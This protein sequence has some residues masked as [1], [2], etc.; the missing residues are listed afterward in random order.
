MGMTRNLKSIAIGILV[1]IVYSCTYRHFD[2][3]LF[4]YSKDTVVNINVSNVHVWN[5]SVNKIFFNFFKKYSGYN[6]FL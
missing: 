2:I 4:I 1:S 5:Y 6:N 3:F